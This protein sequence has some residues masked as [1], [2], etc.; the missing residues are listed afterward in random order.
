M[1]K[2]R[3]IICLA[4]LTIQTGFAL[5]QLKKLEP[6]IEFCGNQIQFQFEKPEL[7]LLKPALVS[8]LEMQLNTLAASTGNA[9]AAAEKTRSELN[10]SDWFTYQLIRKIANSIVPKQDD[11]LGY[12]LT[13][14][15]LLKHLGYATLLGWD[16]TNLLLYVKTNDE[17]YNL[18]IKV[19]KSNHY[20][21]INHHDFSFSEAIPFS[22]LELIGSNNLEGKPFL[23]AIDEI[24]SFPAHET[25]EKILQ[26]EYKAKT[27][28]APIRINQNMQQFFINYPVT[29]Y[30][31]HFNIP[32][33]KL[34]RETLINNLKEQIKGM[35]TRQGVE[36]LMHFTRSAFD[37]AND[38]EI[39]GREK[40][41]SPEETLLYE[42]SDCE[43]RAALFFYL[44][45]EI[46]NLPML[47]LTYSD[48]VNVAVKMDG[49]GY[50]IRH[51]NAAYTICEPT[52][53]K[54]ELGIGQISKARKKDTFDIAYAYEPYE[55]IG[56]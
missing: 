37:F 42:K 6:T 31:T 29:N 53:Q 47:V 10:L 24:P 30:S 22:A 27:Y 17:I 26:Y 5:A 28:Y 56:K 32:L 44:V 16:G 48:H 7:P 36:F 39:F 13:K 43:D 1:N 49:K 40:R 25:V 15:S 3:K 52:P 9:A 8:Q 34:T 51:N 23:F 38:A 35:K 14:A 21:C 45:R 18:P 2:L 41:L 55:P 12:T 46:Y 19:Y 11:F 50:T 4:A 20:V 33:N 54:K